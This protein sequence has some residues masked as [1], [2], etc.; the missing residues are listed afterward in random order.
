MTRR[1]TAVTIGPWPRRHQSAS[2]PTPPGTANAPGTTA[3]TVATTTGRDHSRT[4]HHP[5][6]GARRGHRDERLLTPQATDCQELPAAEVR[7]V[8]VM[9][10]GDVITRLP[11][12][13]ELTATNCS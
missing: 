1:T 5:V 11:V 2:A 9:P 10:S 4:G 6:A 13:V 8:Q 3:A 12:P 7:E